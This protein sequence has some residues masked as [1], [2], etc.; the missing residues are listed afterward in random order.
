MGELSTPFNEHTVVRTHGAG[1]Q[2]MALG[3]ALPCSHDAALELHGA[4]H[5]QTKTN[6][7]LET[8]NSETVA[9]MKQV[10]RSPVCPRM[11][12]HTP[13]VHTRPRRQARSHLPLDHERSTTAYFWHSPLIPAPIVF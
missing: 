8:L 11:G 1:M 10:R 4:T 9:T 5:V 12:L 7:K 2:A 3:A 13:P 6:N